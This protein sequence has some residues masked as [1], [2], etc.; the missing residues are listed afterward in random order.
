ML[1]DINVKNPWERFG[2]KF[3]IKQITKSREKM[4]EPMKTAFW[5]K[6]SQNFKT[7]ASA[8]RK[9]AFWNKQKLTMSSGKF[10]SQLERKSKTWFITFLY[11]YVSW[12]EQDKILFSQ[13][14]PPKF[15]YFADQNGQKEDPTK[16]NSGNFQTQKWISDS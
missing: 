12:V 15:R 16:M 10:G 11:E 6:W 4:F 7:L 9:I 14:T 1:N 3:H 13:L 2:Y 5:E 8:L